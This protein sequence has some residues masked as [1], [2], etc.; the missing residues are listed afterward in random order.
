R[1][2]NLKPIICST[3]PLKERNGAMLGAVVV[4]TDLTHLKKLEDEKRQA[5]RLASVGAL[6]S[7]VAHEIK[8]PLVAI[9]TF[10]ELLPERFADDE[11]R[12][13]FSQIVT[14]EIERIDDL[15]ARLRGLAVHPIRQLGPIDLRL[16]IEETLA[17]LR[18]QLEQSQVRVKTEWSSDAPIV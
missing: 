7:G 4:F 6:A 13:D 17:L 1:H 2:G 8:N 14:R 11:F 15:V 16:P 10:A 18:G 3:S 12:N 5:E 9:K